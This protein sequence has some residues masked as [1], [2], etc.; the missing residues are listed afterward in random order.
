MLLTGPSGQPAI[1][2]ITI[3]RVYA[4]RLV[5]RDVGDL[6]WEYSLLFLEHGGEFSGGRYFGEDFLMAATGLGRDPSQRTK[7]PNE[8]AESYTEEPSLTWESTLASTASISTHEHGRRL[9]L[10]NREEEEL[11]F[12][13][14]MHVMIPLETGTTL[15]CPFHFLLCRYRSH[16]I[17]EWEN[18]MLSHFRGHLPKRIDC[19]F[20]NCK[21]CLLEDTGEEACAQLRSHIAKTHQHRGTVDRGN[22]PDP[23][24]VYHLWQYR[25]I[26]DQENKELKTHGRLLNATSRANVIAARSLASDLA[27]NSSGQTGNQEFGLINFTPRNYLSDRR[28]HRHSVASLEI[29]G[30][31]NSM[32]S[33]WK[34]RCGGC[35]AFVACLCL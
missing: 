20:L 12:S 32:G 26:N 27:K 1:I 22:R 11:S 14:I 33:F 7:R 17:S 35:G 3:F 31:V 24:L 25:L 30:N 28:N 16:D 10:A 29:H 18:H 5:F 8:E 9:R 2:P 19:P 4:A 23:T 6:S 34:Y 15:D 13:K 21:E